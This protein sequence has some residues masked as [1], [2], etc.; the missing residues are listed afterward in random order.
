MRVGQVDKLLYFTIFKF[1]QSSINRIGFR[2]RI[3]ALIDLLKQIVH[4][5]DCILNEVASPLY[6]NISGRKCHICFFH[7]VY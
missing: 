7:K 3:I 4:Q 5:D 6:Y 2:F 1:Q